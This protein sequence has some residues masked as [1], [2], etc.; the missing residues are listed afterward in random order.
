MVNSVIVNGSF[1]GSLSTPPKSVSTLPVTGV[2]S[3][4]VLLSL[5]TTGG[6][7]TAIG[8]A[9]YKEVLTLNRDALKRYVRLSCTAETGAASSNVT[10][11]GYGLKKYG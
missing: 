9:A 3:A 4:V 1:S 8:N 10:C 5:T 2:S 6:S 7:F 11:V